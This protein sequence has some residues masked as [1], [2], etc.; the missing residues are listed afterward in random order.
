MYMC[1]NFKYSSILSSMVDPEI[2]TG[3]LNNIN[4]Q[5]NTLRIGLGVGI[6]GAILGLLII[7]LV[8]FRKKITKKSTM[9]V[10][11]SPNSTEMSVQNEIQYIPIQSENPTGSITISMNVKQISSEEIQNISLI[12]KGNFSEVYKGHWFGTPVVSLVI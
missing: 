2:S 3:G 4:N 6:G 11:L 12:G 7:I 5:N 1:K 8:I 9:N 10:D